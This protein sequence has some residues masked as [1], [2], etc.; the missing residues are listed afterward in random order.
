MARAFAYEWRI[1]LGDAGILIFFVLLPLVYPIAYTLVYNPEVI[2]KI[3]VAVVDNS[4]TAESRS[5]TRDIGSTSAIEIYSYC[6]NLNDARALMDDGQVYGILEIPADYAKCI[7]RGE[8][9]NVMFYAEM[10]LLLRFRTEGFALTDVQIA[11]VGKIT[12]DRINMIGAPAASLSGMPV[13]S[14]SFMLGDTQQGFASFVMPGILVLILQQSM[15]LGAAM[16][17]GTSRQRRRL[18]GGRDP[19][20]PIE[21]HYYAVAWG[22]ALCYTVFYIAPSIYVLHYI[23]EWFNLPHHGA[24]IDYLLFIAPLLLASGFFGITLG[25]LVRD[26]ESVFTVVVVTS[27]IFLF[28]TGLTWPRYIMPEFWQIIGDY[29]PATWGVEGFIR[30][31]TNNATLAE[32]ARPYYWLWG[33]TLAYSITAALTTRYIRRSPKH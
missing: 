7:G 8:T 27:V 22:K 14:E 3:P 28:L 15:V 16:I 24:A 6:A 4:R 2:E 12:A 1:V 17:V 18:Y 25:W 23:P 13:T 33:L 32:S 20:M 30:I 11:E 19:M 9:A 26:R 10:S 5:L 29:I 21:G 31:N